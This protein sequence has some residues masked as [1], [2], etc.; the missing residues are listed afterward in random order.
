MSGSASV[1]PQSPVV[2]D[3]AL[4]QS[5]SSSSTPLSKRQK[6]KLKLKE[7]L[8]AM[9]QLNTLIHR[10]GV[11]KAQ[12]KV[13]S[14]KLEAAYKEYQAIHDLIM[15]LISDDDRES[16][17]EHYETFDNLYDEVSILLEEQIARINCGSQ[18]ANVN[19][20]Q[21]HAVAVPQATVVVQ[22]SLRMPIPTFDGRYERWPKFKAMFKDL[23]DK[24]PD[25]PAVK[26]YHLDKSLV[27]DAA[28]L[29][30]AKT[31]NEGH[32]AHAWKMLEERYENKRH[33]I[34]THIHGLLN[35]KRMSKENHS[36]L[37]HLVDECSRHVASLKFLQQEFTGVSE[38]IFVHL[39]A[40]SLDKETRRRWES[41]IA[42]GQLPNYADTLKFL[43]DQCFVFERCEVSKLPPKVKCDFCGKGHPNFT[44][45]EFKSLSVPQRLKKVR[46]KNVCFNCLRKGHHSSNCQSA[47]FCT[48]CKR[49]H[50]SL[51]H[52]EEQRSANEQEPSPKPELP[53]QQ[54]KEQQPPQVTSATWSSVKTRPLQQVLLLT[55][56][57]DVIDKNNNPRPCRV[58]LDSPSQ[59][60]LEM[61]EKLGLKQNPSNI[62]VAGINNI[63]SH[64]L[65]SCVL[66]IR[67]R[68]SN[69]EA[70]VSCLITDQV[71][72]DLPSSSVEISA[73][74]LPSGVRLAD[75][76]FYQSGKIDLLLGNQWFLK[77]LLPGENILADNY[78]ILREIMLGWVVGGCCD[79]NTTA[80]QTVYSHSVTVDDLNSL[81]QRFWEVEE[82]HSASKVCTEE[83][84]CELHFQATHRRDATGRYVGQLP[85]RNTLDELGDSRQV[86]LRR[87]YALE[88]RL[89]QQPEL[90]QQYTE[91]MAEY[92]DLG[93]CKE[94]DENK[95]MPGIVKWYLPHHAVL[96]PSNTTTKC[97]V[98]F[99]ASA[100]V[101]G[102]SLN[103]VLKVGAINQSDLQSIV[104]RFRE[105]CYVLSA[106]ITKMYRQIIVDECHTPLQR[107]FWR[108]DPSCRLRVL[109]LTTVTYGTASAPFLATRALLQLAIDERAKYPMAADIIEKDCYVDNALFGFNDL[110]TASAAQEQLVQLL[111]AGGFH[112]HK[113]SSNSPKLLGKIPQCDREELVCI[114]AEEAI[115]TLGLMWNPASDELIFSSAPS[116]DKKTPTKRHLLSVIAR[117]YDPLGLVAPVIVIGK[118]LMPRI[119]KAKLNWDEGIT[120]LV[121]RGQSADKLLSNDL[122]W[123]G[124]RFLRDEMYEIDSPEKLEMCV[125]CTSSG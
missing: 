76:Q 52:L 14:R 28:G 58:L 79:V 100:K 31:I 70:N 104:L 105:P 120:D 12:V 24:T 4:G 11:A 44:C 90:K 86:A 106:D 123:I 103:D 1:H 46:E 72:A 99:D 63:K 39:L 32:Y 101:S 54:E 61:M 43:K 47:K 51:L 97:R 107:V 10:R 121:S 7:K 15:T 6:R 50:H 2:A 112:L 25:P 42:H 92:E 64:S 53:A 77:L 18:V 27:G 45:S 111:S 33:S 83:Q 66:K 60:N 55:A 113:W 73:M 56:V 122:W 29:I 37:R 74:N 75:P 115:K 41:T 88:K 109:E 84:E 114:G 62:V 119:W 34:D 22:Q 68:Y 85:L 65:G 17:D 108:I 80:E 125:R 9:E 124:P 13:Y 87:F 110:S 102:R 71:T 118:L 94:I 3:N 8:Q 67:S 30:D 21:L 26:L 23:V 89:A 5:A 20:S 69:F 96:K 16:H 57:V 49:R 82:V 81:I 116:D 38:Q 36:E 93:H 35:L 98:V 59:A 19:A 40:N 117:M 95:D 48:K 91:F 78:P